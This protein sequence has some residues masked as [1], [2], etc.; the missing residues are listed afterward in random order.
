[1]KLKALTLLLSTA[2]AIAGDS[3]FSADGKSV[4][5]APQVESGSLARVDVETGKVAL[6][7][8]PAELKDKEISGLAQGA[9]GEALFS[10]G[11][12]V[13]VATDAGVIKKVLPTKPVTGAEGLFVGTKAD[14]P[15]MDWL[16]VTGEDKDRAGDSVFYARHKGGKAFGTVFCRRI[17][18]VRCGTFAPDGRFFFCAQGDL[19]EGGFSVEEPDT[20]LEATLVGARIA[21]LAML[22]TDGGNAGSA[23]VGGIAPAGKWLY[24]AVSGRHYGNILRVPIPAKTLYGPDTENLPEARDQL[25]AMRSSLEKTEVLVSDMEAISAFCATEVNGEPRVFFRTRRGE[26]GLSLWL[27]EGKGE[28]RRLAAEPGA[29]D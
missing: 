3:F 29:G 14:S 16:F 11:D 4:T 19:W 5:F 12:A 10:A 2:A 7:P 6:I 13:W 15:L 18:N 26:H 9:Q 21:P 27:W 25:E 1:M 22:N 8:L 28:P 24:A 20:G 17:S 23:W